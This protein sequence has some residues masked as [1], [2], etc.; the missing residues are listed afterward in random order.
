MKKFFLTLFV[1][2]ASGTAL[3]AQEKKTPS[4]EF[5]LELS[6]STLD[7]KQGGNKEVTVAINRSKSFSKSE[8]VL[9]LSSGLPQ[10]V[11]VTFE[12]AEGLI[13]SS[14]AKVAVAENVKAGNYMIILNGTIR[15][16]SKGATLKLVVTGSNPDLSAN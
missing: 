4:K 5:I 13:E 15:N 16:K 8:V 10:G 2:I 9:G 11:T 12:P 7:V 14:V 3:F 6:S 1:A